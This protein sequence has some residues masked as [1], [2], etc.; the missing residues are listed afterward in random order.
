MS[1]L[2][3]C[4][5]LALGVL[6]PPP[7]WAQQD[8]AALQ[9][10][11]SQVQSQGHARVIVELRLAGG[12][13]VPEGRLGS[14]AAVA[15]QRQDIAATGA[16]VIASVRGTGSTVLHQYDS[17]PMVAM[18]VDAAGLAQLLASGL[19]VTR[20]MEDKVRYPVL[21]QSGPLVQAD[22]AWTQGFDGTGWTVALIDSGVDKNHPFLVGKVVSEACFVNQ[23]PTYHCPN[24]LASQIGPGAAVP[25]AGEDHGTHVAGIAA[26]H[27]P[28]AVPPPSPM[29]SGMAR[30]AAIIAIDVFG[31][32]GFTYDSDLIAGLTQVYALRSTYNIASVN[33][34]LGDGVRNT[35]F[36]D[37]DP[38][39]PAIDNLRSV[40]IATVI[41]AGNDSYRNG[42]SGPAC[43]STAVSVGSTTKSDGVSSF[44]NAASFMSLWAPGSS[45]KSSI[46]GG[47]YAFF[48]GTSMATPHV[49]GAWAVLKQAN[50]TASVA[51]ILT[52]LQSTGTLITDTRIGGTVT[53]P[54]IDIKDALVLL[55]PTPTSINLTSGLP[56]QTLNI[57]ITGTG[58]LS[59]ATSAFGAGVTVNS[60]TFNSSTSLTTNIT[61]ATNATPGT[62][63]V[64]VTNPGGGTGNLTNAFTIAATNT[65]PFGWL[66]APAAGATVGGP[67]VAVSGWVLDQE[68]PTLTVQFLV[69][70]VVVSSS[71]ARSARGDVCAAFSTV[72]HCASSQPGVTFSWNA[73][74]VANGPHTLALRAIDP[75]GLSTTIGT[76][77]VTVSN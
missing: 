75:A 43:I 22:Q 24:G 28:N 68:D 32:S 69:N 52:A 7:A 48:S 57:A 8:P 40:D 47:G 11:H 65:A 73:T 31:A 19:Y 67:A 42:I 49:T 37:A 74:T 9:R 54:R 23:L 51:T 14:A 53:K 15:I 1:R 56:G 12:A 18:E 55:G 21:Y 27:G 38:L 6:V 66:D 36:C 17:V 72:A 41:A 3:R 45:I 50:P 5:V 61:I 44:S 60:T 29:M 13:H 58:F 26:G 46:N 25:P 16:Q 35:T 76:R 71:P 59:G 4:L 30:G 10:I 33:M 39:K 64:S 63:T 20:I 77:T 34:S 62:R 70:G 2:L